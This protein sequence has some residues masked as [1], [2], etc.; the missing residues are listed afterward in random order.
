M[1]EFLILNGSK[2]WVSLTPSFARSLDHHGLEWREF[3][4]AYLVD[5]LRGKKDNE[6]L[7]Y[8]ADE[9]IQQ[10]T[11]AKSEKEPELKEEAK[12]QRPNA[13]SG[14]SSE[15]WN[16]LRKVFVPHHIGAKLTRKQVIDMVEAAYHG[17]NRSSVIPSDYCYNIVNNGIP[18]KFHFFEYLRNLRRSDPQYKVL[19][20]NAD[21]EGP[22][23][24][25]GEIVGE[26][27]KGET[28]PRK[29]PKWPS[30]SK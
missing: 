23:Y 26:W 4:F 14:T 13:S 5:F 22:I 21:Y 20:E 9:E 24:W 19:G 27:I 2:Y 15:I 6:F 1:P 29:G 3:A 10:S 25:N 7:N 12:P 8:F 18:F 11:V 30:K 28:E 16:K 17:T